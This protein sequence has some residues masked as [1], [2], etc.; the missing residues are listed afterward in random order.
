MCN[1]D[2]GNIEPV[3]GFTKAQVAA[4]ILP[5]PANGSK[6]SPNTDTAVQPVQHSVKPPKPGQYMCNSFAVKLASN[7][8][9]TLTGLHEAMTAVLDNPVSRPSFNQCCSTSI[10]AAS[11]GLLSYLVRDL[12]LSSH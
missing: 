7:P 3:S 11:T 4:A 6:P 5:V 10:N 8:I 2:L 12:V 1:A 9:S